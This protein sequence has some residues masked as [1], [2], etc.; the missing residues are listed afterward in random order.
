MPDTPRESYGSSNPQ[1]AC[2]RCAH[3]K[4][5]QHADWCPWRV[6][7]V[8]SNAS[9]RMTFFDP[10]MWIDAMRGVPMI[11]ASREELEGRYPK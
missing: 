4:R 9:G 8:D 6:Q 7:L 2:Q 11:E 5:Y 3:G 1:H 10:E